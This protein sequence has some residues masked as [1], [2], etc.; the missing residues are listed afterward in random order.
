VANVW[1]ASSS[2]VSVAHT[3][4]ASALSRQSPT[5]PI[6][7]FAIPPHGGGARTRR[8]GGPMS[9]RCG[10]PSFLTGRGDA[11]LFPGSHDASLVARRPL[12][13]PR[14]YAPPR[15]LYV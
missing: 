1:R 2:L 8:S 5:D 3:D 12:D 13:S 10:A 14:L 6:D 11:Q 7:F 9:A 15:K 4:S